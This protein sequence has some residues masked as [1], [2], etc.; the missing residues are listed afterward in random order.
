VH[1]LISLAC[2][3]TWKRNKKVCRP[4][5]LQGAHSSTRRRVRKGD[6]FVRVDRRDTQV[7][8]G[9]ALLGQG[10]LFYS[11]RP[12]FPCSKLRGAA[13]RSRECGG[14]FRQHTFHVCILNL[15]D[16]SS[17]SL[18][19]YAAIGRK[20]GAKTTWSLQAI[21]CSLWIVKLPNFYIC[22]KNLHNKSTLAKIIAKL[23][24]Q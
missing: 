6:F 9:G 17:Q 3:L 22:C 16:L 19:N 5:H 12:K 14:A 8:V 7:A 2:R 11:G 23:S 13:E 4:F 20:V 15:T 24:S 21:F 1:S 18:E 10:S